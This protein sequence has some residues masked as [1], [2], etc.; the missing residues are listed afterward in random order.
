M[1]WGSFKIKAASTGLRIASAAE[2]YTDKDPATDAVI[3]PHVLG[4]A[5]IRTDVVSAIADKAQERAG[6]AIRLGEMYFNAKTLLEL[7]KAANADGKWTVAE[8]NAF[9][10]GVQA[11]VEDVD[12]IL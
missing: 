10:D 9:V 5:G 4:K 2:N 3:D 11:I 7:Y 6:V 12:E 1:G 8:M